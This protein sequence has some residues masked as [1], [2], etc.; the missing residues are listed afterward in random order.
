MATAEEKEKKKE[1]ILKAAIEVFR[2][3]GFARANVEEI[4]R[5]AGIAKGTVYL[6]FKSKTEILE[7]ILERVIVSIDGNIEELATS[8]LSHKE[9]IKK[10]LWKQFERHEAALDAT[11]SY[12]EMLG[13]LEKEERESLLKKLENKFNK[14]SQ[15]WA[16]VLKQSELDSANPG[17][18]RVF[19]A[20]LDGL[21]LHF[22]FFIQNPKK[23]R[24]LFQDFLSLIFP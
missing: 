14:L 20:S 4:S 8:S 11:P 23:R 10:L 7:Y 6:Y 3:K 17:Y 1:Q 21:M 9:D 19:V 5:A 24:E 12:F 22:A 13:A 16:E 15:S 2:E 18:T